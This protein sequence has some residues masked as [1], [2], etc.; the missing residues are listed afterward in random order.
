MSEWILE[1]ENKEQVEKLKK[2]FAESQKP[3]SWLTVVV[4]DCLTD[5]NGEWDF[6]EDGPLGVIEVIK[7]EIK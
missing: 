3:F 7:Q 6:D 5:F 1:L 2:F 4:I